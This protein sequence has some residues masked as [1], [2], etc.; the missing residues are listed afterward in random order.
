MHKDE[1]LFHNPEALLIDGHDNAIIGM[2]NFC[3][4]SVVL[5]DPVKVVDNL[6][7]D[8]ASYDEA[9]EFFVYN[10]ESAYMGKN[11]PAFLVRLGQND[12][13]EE[14]DVQEE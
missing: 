6:M 4:R 13:E 1:I 14:A 11:T 5:Y 2:A 10:I 12:E 7:K 8:G 3:G 9:Y